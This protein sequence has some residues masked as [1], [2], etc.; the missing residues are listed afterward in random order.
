MRALVIALAVGL[1]GAILAFFL[2]PTIVDQPRVQAEL[3]RLVEG[4][5]GAGFVAEGG[6]GIDL[7]P[8]P[9]LSL[10]RVVLGSTP[11]RPRLAADRMDLTIDPSTLLTR[12][13]TTGHL[14]ISGVTLVRPRFA[15]SVPSAGA[16]L[17]AIADFLRADRFQ[18]LARVSVVDGRLDLETSRPGP[19]DHVQALAAVVQRAA[20]SG[21][22]MLT[23][24]ALTPA[25]EPVTLEGEVAEPTANAPT[26]IRFALSRGSVHDVGRIEFRGF[27]SLGSQALRLRGALAI[28]AASAGAL[29]KILQPFD[30]A[31]ILPAVN[32]A[33]AGPIAVRSRLSLAQGRLQLDDLDLRLGSAR[34]GGSLMMEMGAIARLEVRLS[35]TEITLDAGLPDKERRAGRPLADLPAIIAAIHGPEAFLGSV[36]LDVDALHLNGETIRQT[37]LDLGLD[38][39]GAVDIA[40]ASARLPGNG[41]ITLTGRVEPHDGQGQLTGRLGLSADDLPTTLAFLGPAEP[42]ADL[43]PRALD[44][45]ASLRID[46]AG[47]EATGID[48]R[49]DSS[50]V[51]GDA[52]YRAAATPQLAI[53]ALAD[54]IS[55]A[56]APR[57]PAGERLR[58]LLAPLAGLDLDLDLAAQRG[59]VGLVSLGRSRLHAAIEH[60]VLELRE[61]TLDDVDAAHL[62]LTGRA[63]LRGGG[64]DLAGE[65]S[66][67]QPLP[68][69]RALW[70][71]TPATMARFGPVRLNAAL[72]GFPDRTEV[73][74]GLEAA[75]IHATLTGSTGPD[76]DLAHTDLR[77]EAGIEAL[78]TGLRN[79]GLAS[80]ALIGPA[81][82]TRI[83]A[84]IK[85]TGE[86]WRLTGGGSLPDGLLEVALSL[87]TRAAGP[88]LDGSVAL[89]RLDPTL[90]RTATDLLRDWASRLTPDNAADPT[91]YLGRLPTAAIPWQRLRAA[92][93]ELTLATGRIAGTRLTLHGRLDDGDLVIDGL[94]LP[95]AGGRLG[96]ALTLDADGRSGLMGARLDLTAADAAR[97]A[98][99]MG[100]GAGVDGKA[101]LSLQLAGGGQSIAELT[102]DLEGS[103]HLRLDRGHLAVDGRTLDV[104]ELGGPLVVERGV[105]EAP[106]PGLDLA[107]PGGT[108][109]IP[110]RFDLAAWIAEIGV[111]AMTREPPGAPPPPQRLIGAPGRL[112]AVVPAPPP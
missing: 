29:T 103:G 106:P 41:R 14:A 7:L 65:I 57:L 99:L 107:F 69:L 79:A 13:L 84:Q 42:S 8:V 95:L 37:H 17:A 105:V 44:G 73:N 1:V 91:A 110:L 70:P 74:S 112:E 48:L 98:G 55:L 15:A 30:P 109:R 23:A 96:G 82:P 78:W 94:D 16:G 56:R 39:S 59:L 62:R 31:A 87:T 64:F 67:P 2:G 86:R 3:H 58:S 5:T 36:R 71:Q 10:K 85:R 4:A 76:L 88:R 102:D 43:L 101:D 80:P 104:Q 21:R 46:A 27:G 50:T 33:V 83:D 20:V 100:F 49:L 66:T 32:V 28:D 111:G 77:L 54:R 108:G 24:S 6:I 25:G 40:A 75:G 72:H 60:G 47:I 35:A 18:S 92:S 22:T 51:R 11:A 19:L 61:L 97:L 90:T 81:G 68:I 93:G 63:D 53:T 9:T 34:F 89:P 12:A 26:A 52:R 38:G 45:T